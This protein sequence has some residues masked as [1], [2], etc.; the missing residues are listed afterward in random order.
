MRAAVVWTRGAWPAAA[1]LAVRLPGVVATNT[2]A[3]C[4]TPP[5]IG[6]PGADAAGAGDLGPQEATQQRL[7]HLACK[8]TGQ[9]QHPASTTCNE[10]RLAS[11]AVPAPLA[12]ACTNEANPLRD[13]LELLR[14]RGRRRRRVPCAAGR[15]AGPL[16]PLRRACG[17]Q[18]EQA[19]LDHMQCVTASQPQPP[20]GTDAGQTA[21]RRQYLAA[22][23]G[24]GP[25]LRLAALPGGLQA[26]VAPC[27]PRPLC[28]AG[29]WCLQVCGR[30]SGALLS[31][32][33]T[34]LERR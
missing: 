20:S 26:Q 22:S 34:L 31:N 9:V 21:A 11:Q 25:L 33:T 13:G 3:A 16:L 1:A 5:L 17:E 10:L 2:S 30:A 18:V 12:L 15:D 19:A 4:P 23:R 29:T 32:H 7:P 24:H 8:D 27:L 14:G 6:L 28:A